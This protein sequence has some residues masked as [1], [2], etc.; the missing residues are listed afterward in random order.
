M[1]TTTTATEAATTTDRAAWPRLRE[2]PEPRVV[3][4]HAGHGSGSKAFQ[5]FL[6]G[7]PQIYMIPAY[8]LVYLYPH[9]RRWENELKD[10]WTWAAIIDA[11]CVQHA[12]VIDPKMIPGHDGMTTLGESRDDHVAIDGKLFRDF[13]NHLLRDEPIS[14]RA[15]VLAVHY[16]YAFCRGEDFGL[17]RVLVYHIHVQAYVSTYLIHDFPDMLI[18]GMVRDQR[19]NHRGRYLHSI[20]T[21]QDQKLH[22][23]DAVLLRRRNYYEVCRLLY[24]PDTSITG[25]KPSNMRVVRA[26]DLHLRLEEVM[27]AVAEFLDIDFHPCLLQST[28]GGLLFWGDA[29]YDMRPMNR[30]NPRVVSL[31]WQETL[32]PM[33]WFVLEGLFYDYHKEYGYTPYKYTDDTWVNR[34]KLFL[35]MLLP[36]QME[37]REFLNY[38]K[39]ATLLDFVV[40]CWAEATG[41]APLKDYSFNAY[42][43]HR[44][45][46]ED[47]M[48]WK[49]RWYKR[50]LVYA[51]GAAGNAPAS[52][53]AATV[54]RAAQACYIAANLGRYGWAV[55]SQPFWVFK[56]WPL[57]ISAFRRLVTKTF[58]L[59]KALP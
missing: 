29:I 56:R 13:L 25:A 49:P 59:P 27:R 14:S 43:R 32:A 7:H 36:S 6:D 48:L 18:V 17:K 35:L 37:R 52:L 40:A 34:A 47:L 11:F 46:S 1:M 45:G 51:L 24:H 50:F 53:L 54:K 5:S 33:D 26:E 31:D 30:F 10:D 16:A 9:W 22:R 28:F 38:L 19:S 12:S 2:I 58:V 57:S 23:S 42:Y 3:C 20:A 15:F 39:P 21:V 41:K 4:L 44:W 55:L 8:P